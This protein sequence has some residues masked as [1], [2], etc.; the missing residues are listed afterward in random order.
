[1]KQIIYVDSYFYST[2]MKIQ[3]IFLDELALFT[4]PYRQL[5]DGDLLPWL[6]R[7]GC[8]SIRNE[9]V[10]FESTNNIKQ[11]NLDSIINPPTL[12]HTQLTCVSFDLVL[13]TNQ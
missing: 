9:Y 6:F 12:S 8:V 3:S 10:T 5:F 7:H 2:G 4:P 11:L 13:K 1:M